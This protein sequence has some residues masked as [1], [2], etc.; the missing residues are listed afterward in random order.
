M[1]ELSYRMLLMN[2]VVTVFAPML[3]IITGNIFRK[4]QNID[5]PTPIYKY[6]LVISIVPTQPIMHTGKKPMS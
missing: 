1:M 6:K 2:N 5:P 3:R 4:S